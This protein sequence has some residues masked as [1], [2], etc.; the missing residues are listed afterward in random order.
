MIAPRKNLTLA[1]CVSGLL[2]SGLLA[3]AMV[4]CAKPGV[5]EPREPTRPEDKV[6]W[7]YEIRAS[8]DG[9]LDIVADFAGP[10]AGELAVDED[11]LPF[12]DGLV[13]YDGSGRRVK[14]PL[15]DACAIGCRARYR[16]R[17]LDAARALADV[18][19]AI[20]AGGALFAP[21]SAWL[22]RP[23]R[24]PWS[25]RCRFHVVPAAGTRFLTGVRP[26]SGT[27][28]TYETPAASIDEGSFAA[29]GHLRVRHV[30]ERGVDVAIAPS[31]RL[32]DD[33]VEHW[34]RAELDAVT[35]YVG[36][37]PEDR[38]WIF[39][40]PGTSEV[41]RGKT[42]GDSGA[43]VFVRLGTGVTPSNLLE[44]WVLAHELIHVASPSLPSEEAWFSEGLATYV[45]PLARE[46]AGLLRP[47]KVWG[48]LVEGLP[49]GL[50]KP[51]DKG[52]SGA[53]DI[54]RVYWGGALYFLLADLGIRD[55]TLGARSL[56]DVVRETARQGANVEIHWTLEHMLDEGDRATGTRTL[57]TLYE[58]MGHAPSEVDLGALW[59]QLGV[60]KEGSSIRFDDAAPLAS[61]RH[62]TDTGHP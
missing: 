44:D 46:R 25:G 21:P 11:S 37:M 16:V 18:D 62:A 59:V 50:A 47:E 36:R 51:G 14:G 2:V 26:L 40:A 52:L 34:V 28:D 48:D 38:T 22:L 35:S 39:L 24:G 56:D 57:H 58:R 13:V 9:A 41:M 29:F 3:V 49:Q 32:S 43:S 60:R 23:T 17:L 5:R 33:L 1:G 20:E 27:R 30:S 19:T 31:I 6:I 45:E 7:S 61:T 15:A 53:R 4:A 12:V 54:G 10:L 55:K 8:A 42:L